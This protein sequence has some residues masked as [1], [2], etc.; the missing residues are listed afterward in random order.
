VATRAV[1][2]AEM[3]HGG[4]LCVDR[5]LMPGGKAQRDIGKLVG[6]EGGYVHLYC[7]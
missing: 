6:T 1:L 7:P 2:T 5:L 3:P 4:F